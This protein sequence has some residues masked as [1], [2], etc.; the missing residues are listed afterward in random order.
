MHFWID[1]RSQACGFGRARVAASLSGTG[2]GYHPRRPRGKSMVTPVHRFP[3]IQAPPSAP[4]R[5]QRC[6]GSHSHH[7][8]LHHSQQPGHQAQ[9]VHDSNCHLA[10][11]SLPHTYASG[12]S[13]ALDLEHGSLGLAAQSDSATAPQLL[14]GNE[15]RSAESQLL[16]THLKCGMWASLALATVFVAGA[17]FYFDHQGTGLEVLIFCAFSATFFLAACTV[18]L[19]RRS[20]DIHFPPVTPSVASVDHV[21]VNATAESPQI[22]HQSVAN[23]SQQSATAA[24][25]VAVTPPP[26]PP[27]PYH[28]AILLPENS[29]DVE[30]SPPPAYDKIVI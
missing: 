20:R 10:V 28:I 8:H 15:A 13:H 9:A 11:A 26:A 2:F 22:V 29:K 30:E 14:L 25:I 18:S 12:P 3:A 6:Q 7:H 5:H 16:P 1:K 27:P 24:T 21:V 4:P 19:C 17:K 23:L